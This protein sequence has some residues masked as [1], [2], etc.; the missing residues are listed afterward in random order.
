MTQSQMNFVFFFPD[1]MRA[2][3]VGCYG[4]PFVQTPNLDQFAEQ[5][6]RFEQCH[7]QNTVCSPS[8]SSVMTGLYPHVSGHRTLWHLLRPHE[9]SLFR[10]LKEEGYQIKWFGKNDLYS[11]EY[12]REILG[13]DAV[14]DYEQV[15]R[16]TFKKKNPF[17]EDDPRFY[18]FLMEPDVKETALTETEAY[19]Q[20]AISF[21]QSDEA[22]EKPFMIFLPTLAPHAPYVIPEPYYSMYDP[23]QL[24]ALRPVAD[25]RKPSYHKLIRRYRR[26]DQIT[27]DTLARAHA[28]Y[29]GMISHVDAVFGQLLEALTEGGHREQ[30][31]VI[32]ASDHGDYAGDYGLV[33]KWPTGMEDCLT[34]VP[35]LIQTPAGRSGHVV[36]EQVELFDIMATVL[37]LAGIEPKHDH[38]AR[39][40]VPQ[41]SGGAGDP[42]RYVFAEGGYD[43]RELHCFE[44]GEVSDSFFVTT[45][46]NPY[47][48]KGL[49]QQEHPHSVCRTTMIRSLEYKL[50]RRTSDRSELYDLRQDPEE[51]HNVYE[52][53]NYA[54]IKLQLEQAMLDWYMSTSDVVPREKDSRLF[55]S[56]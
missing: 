23:K 28:V 19:V 4:H 5:G 1:E 35:L 43:V 31:T 2:E 36:K 49:Q 45:P 30:T 55:I 33:E 27:D 3:S 34:R 12:L 25:D 14:Q 18:S 38:F 16:E 17:A 51:L 7:V 52:D 6:V 9:P 21:L 13:E 41:L 39:S 10:Y 47:W 11:S 46:Q 50:I 22:K 48:P 40:L 37:E 56:R 44:G 8:R 54:G 26:L 20:K 24:P 32:V 42:D 29:L 15:K 53:P